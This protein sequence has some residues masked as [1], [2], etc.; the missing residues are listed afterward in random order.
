MEHA[1]VKFDDL[2]DYQL[3]DLYEE[4]AGF[5]SSYYDG[6][7]PANVWVNRFAR[8]EACYRFVWG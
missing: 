7:I 3:D 4:Y 5:L 8:A 6:V 2:D 1:P